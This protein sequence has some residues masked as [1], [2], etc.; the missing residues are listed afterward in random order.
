M[1]PCCRLFMLSRGV[2]ST[3]WKW[4]ASY[5]PTFDASEMADMSLRQTLA[6]SVLTTPD[7]I[8]RRGDA[9]ERELWLLDLVKQSQACALASSYSTC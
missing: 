7:S 5:C 4:N 1:L 8:A 2:P 9:E 3:G 6:L